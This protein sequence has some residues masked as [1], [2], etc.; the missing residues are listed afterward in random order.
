MASLVWGLSEQLLF[1]YS[2]DAVCIFYLV[3]RALDTV[4]DDMTIPIPV[5]V[6]MLKSFYKNLWDPDW[7][8]TESNDKDRI[9]LENF[10]SVSPIVFKIFFVYS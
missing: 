8:Y 3:L 1:A 10:P 7:N 2:R 4:E 6:P 5:K 9:V